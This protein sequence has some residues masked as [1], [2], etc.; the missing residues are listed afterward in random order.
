MG[1][2]SRLFRR[3]PPA[4]EPDPAANLLEAAPADVY[5]GFRDL[6]LSLRATDLDRSG[7]GVLAALMEQGLEDVT[8]TLAVVVDGAASLYFSNGGGV[9]GAGEHEPVREASIAFL[10]RT[11]D[12]IDELTRT[13][14][15]PLPRRGHVR[16]YIVASD[17]VWTTEIDEDDLTTGR[18]VLSPLFDAGQAVIASI[19][20]HAGDGG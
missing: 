14:V 7:D 3:P 19:R 6:V 4:P 15:Y 20:T 10:A 11:A 9:L 13:S 18:H 16:F 12:V 5:V 1:F 2:F 17:G 8:V